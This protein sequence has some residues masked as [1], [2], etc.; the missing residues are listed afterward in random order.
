[1]IIGG[2]WTIKEYLLNVIDN[3]LSELLRFNGKKLTTKE[4][5]EYVSNFGM[6]EFSRKDYMDV[7]KNI[8]SSSASR[9]LKKGVEIGVLKI[10]G[11]K[12]KT[13]YTLHNK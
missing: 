4:R 9:D 8:S 1:M 5:L 11:E 7:F 10:T 12:N 6:P 2:G 3:S 13:K